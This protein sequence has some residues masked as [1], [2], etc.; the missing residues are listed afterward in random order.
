MLV[1]AKIKVEKIT[2]NEYTFSIDSP[3]QNGDNGY[4]VNTVTWVV[5]QEVL[6]G[7]TYKNYELCR[8]SKVKWFTYEFEEEGTYIIRL[9]MRRNNGMSII[10]DTLIIKVDTLPPTVIDEPPI[11]DDPD[12]TVIDDGKPIEIPPI[13]NDL[14]KWLFAQDQNSTIAFFI[15]AI[16][17]AAATYW[18]L[19]IV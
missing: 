10:P 6:E 11:D 19:M 12:D 3:S 7:T 8:V 18:Y 16:V 13:T 9:S 1:E 17:G 4:D 14:L 5:Q 15:G 2:E